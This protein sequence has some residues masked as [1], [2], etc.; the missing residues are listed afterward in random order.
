M[1]HLFTAAAE[2]ALEA[3]SQWS[4]R[5]DSDALELPELLMGL[6][7]EPECRAALILAARGVG[8]PEIQ[9][10]WPN[11]TCRPVGADAPRRLSEEVINSFAAAESQLIDFPRPLALATEFILLGIVAEG[12]HVGEWLA[13]QGLSLDVVEVEIHALYDYKP[14][15]LAIPDEELPDQLD[16]AEDEPSIAADVLPTSMVATPTPLA[17]MPE[18][19]ATPSAAVWRILDVEANRAGEAFRVVEDYVRFALDDRH[20]ATLVKEQRHEFATVLANLKPELRYA[21]RDTL[22]DVGTTISTAAERQRGDL[23]GVVTANLRR[24]AE[25]LRSLEEYSKI[26]DPQVAA[27][28]EALR[29]R[30]YTLERAIHVTRT[31]CERLAAAQLYVLVDGGAS[32]AALLQLT[33]PLIAAGVHVV[34]LRDKQLADRELLARARLL[35]SLTRGTETLFIVNDRPDLAA[36][37]DADGVH[38]GQDELSVK[39]ARAV[40]GPERLVGVSTHSIEQ[41]RA[42]VLAGANYLGVGPTFPSRT[43]DFASFTGLPLLHAVAA[44]IRLP[45][46]AIGGIGPANLDEVLATGMSR[47]AVG[48]AVTSAENPHRAACEILERLASGAA[49]YL[50]DD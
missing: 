4:S 27:R 14:G 1:G 6:L 2:R 3:A 21:A 40:I 24:I 19:G 33:G 36:L 15:P 13:Q 47:V 31:S 9:R 35:R 26:V 48:A 50:A 10:E 39:D 12:G 28:F 20:L 5:S 30:S 7:A 49:P 43:K 41:A 46:F 29:Y 8:S 23:C 17:S 42:A 22:A 32:D 45:S 44:E 37:A 38:V 34:Q 11:L 18:S 25:A 16:I